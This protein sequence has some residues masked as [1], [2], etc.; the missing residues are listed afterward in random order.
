M[1]ATLKISIGLNLILLGCL[2]FVLAHQRRTGG[3]AATS[4]VPPDDQ[5]VQTAAVS[6]AVQPD[7]TKPFRWSQLLASSD[8]YAFVEKLRSAGCPEATI[9]DIVAGDVRR[10]FAA[11]R[12]QLNLAES[13]AGP[14]SQQAEKRLMTS[15]LSGRP[16]AAAIQLPQ[17]AGPVG[18]NAAAAVTAPQ[19]TAGAADA[20]PLFLQN[21]NWSAL[22]FDS[23]QQDAIAQIR[24]QFLSQINSQ[25]QNPGALASQS[26]S[27]QAAPATSGSDTPTRWHTALQYADDQLRD[28]LGAQGYMA[29][30]QQQY[31]A[32]FQPQV[33][34][35]VDGGN[36]TI[37]PD[38]FSLK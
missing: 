22:G 4:V 32:W 3:G 29:Y 21:V 26:S 37:N 9:Q 28:A 25:N 14:W 10:A 13:G 7:E 16:P 6:V 31:Y 23:S 11:E 20:Y 8:Y 38:A 19:R 2:A 34:A 24:Q 35:N 30:E 27:D 36:L 17:G 1:K 12:Q 33:M 15:L 18:G 5:P